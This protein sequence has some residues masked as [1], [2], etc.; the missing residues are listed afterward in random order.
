MMASIKSRGIRPD[1]P[2]P[3]AQVPGVKAALEVDNLQNSMQLCGWSK[4]MVAKAMLLAES[5][6]K[7]GYADFVT[8]L[9]K[10]ANMAA[11]GEKLTK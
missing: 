11:R 9:K 2:L 8:C 10:Y 1:F 6:C 5:D 4:A 3:A 7:S